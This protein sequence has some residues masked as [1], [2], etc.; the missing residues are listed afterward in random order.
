[1]DKDFRSY[2]FENRDLGFSDQLIAPNAYK[3]E[4]DLLRAF[5]F[6]FAAYHYG[7]RNIFNGKSSRDKKLV[8]TFTIEELETSVYKRFENIF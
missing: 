8:L 7:F 1:M 4:L 3:N 5:S 6:C 2:L